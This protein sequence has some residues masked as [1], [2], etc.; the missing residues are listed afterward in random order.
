[1]L[2]SYVQMI[3]RA[4]QRVESPH[5]LISASDG[6]LFEPLSLQ[7]KRVLRLLVTGWTNQEIAHEL[8]VSVNTVKYHIKHLYQKLGV[9]NRQQASI[10]AHDLSLGEPL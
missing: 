1:M 9:R 3:L 6:L 2:R 8:M 4:A 10:A 7:E 5:A